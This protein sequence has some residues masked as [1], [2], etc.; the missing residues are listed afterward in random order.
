[1]IDADALGC[2]ELLL[3]DE[4][5]PHAKQQLQLHPWNH[6]PLELPMTS[7]EEVRSWWLQWLLSEHSQT[8]DAFSGSKL[9][10]VTNCVAI[11][12]EGDLD[13]NDYT[14]LADWLLAEHTQRCLGSAVEDP[15]CC[16][17]VAG[18]CSGKTLLLSQ[19]ITNVITRSPRG[20][21]IPILVRAQLLQ[22]WLQSHP[23][24]FATAWNWIDAYIG[25]HHKSEPAVYRMLRQAMM[26]RRALLLIDGLDEGG[27]MREQLE[28]HVTG[29]LAQQGHLLLATSRPSDTPE[30]MLQRFSAFKC[31]SL[32]PLSE[33]MQQAALEN[34][35]GT[36][37]A[38][39]LLA[40]LK[41]E[42]L[43]TRITCSPLMLSVVVGVRDVCEGVEMP[44]NESGFF[45]VATQTAFKRIRSVRDMQ[46]ELERSNER[47]MAVSE[48]IGRTNRRARGQSEESHTLQAMRSLCWTVHA[49]ESRVITSEDLRY[50]ALRI[51]TQ[52]VRSLLEAVLQKSLS[53]LTLL[54]VGPLQDGVSSSLSLDGYLE[55]LRP[56]QLQVSHLSFQEYM[57]AHAIHAAGMPSATPVMIPKLDTPPWQWTSWWA[58][59]LNI[60]IKMGPEFAVGLLRCSGVLGQTL[61]LSGKTLH[62]TLHSEHPTAL[63]AVAQLMSKLTTLQL[64]N[65]S[66]LG[67]GQAWIIAKGLEGNTTL[68][69]LDLAVSAASTGIG[70]EGGKALAECLRRNR[71]LQFLDITGNFLGESGG[72]AIADAVTFNAIL[73]ELTLA[74][75][76]LAADAGKAFA[77]TLRENRA[78]TKLD[79]TGNYLKESVAALEAACKQATK[80][81]HVLLQVKLTGQKG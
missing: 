68:T 2:H 16:L 36:D 79:L 34:R 77:K 8:D 60:G 1:V 46:L 66:R 75:T 76:G 70:S 30:E 43:S 27:T 48:E 51:G 10:V 19:V 45:D 57:V 42:D 13:I 63:R 21:L 58:N 11:E 59:T 74:Y 15:A 50:V 31:L 52:P 56:L 32:L 71:A 53:L 47:G 33:S 29:V 17:I 20:Q 5:S 28:R 41:R 14:S 18:A 49:K 44:E 23:S 37:G 35:L 61:D 54:Q 73:R 40:F 65:S 78:L 24:V 9:D 25:L 39:E 72:I 26:A 69:S 38:E 80:E 62:Q 6:A 67:A 12:I 81:R 4:S 22:G 7:F 3:V 55:A 64:W